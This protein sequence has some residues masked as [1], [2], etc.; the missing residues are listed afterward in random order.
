MAPGRVL[1]IRRGQALSPVRHSRHDDARQPKAA[2]DGPPKGGAL[3]LAAACILSALATE[4]AASGQ[5]VRDVVVP[6]IDGP[7]WTV[8]G[9]PDLGD[10][11][12]PQQQP[13]DFAIWQAADGSWQLWSCI[14][15]TRCGGKSRLFYRWEGPRLTQG[16][17]R[18][19][20]IAM[21]ADKRFGETPGGLQA[22]HV[23]RTGD[24][25][26]M[27]YGDWENICLATSEDGKTFTRQLSDDGRAGMFGEGAGANT[28]D[29]MAILVGDL[30]HCYYTAFPGGKGAVYC[31]TSRDLRNWS[32]SR[33][34]SYGG[35]AGSGP[36]SAECAHV[37]YHEGHYYLFRT[38][39]YGEDAQTSVYRSQDPMH[40]GVDDDSRF[41][42]TLPVAAPE[43]VVHEAREY[44]ASLRP[45]LKG[46]RVARLRW[47]EGE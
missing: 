23:V 34:V 36:T 28:R 43:V 45:D 18:P 15:H 44:I 2:R 10:L 9:D 8:A 42:G 30:W 31:R 26:H 21:Q 7:W 22:P 46:I 17:W 38:Q 25:Y 29:P 24:R 14:R 37:V 35:R 39:R 40:F 13:V 3:A 20:G 12:D 11:T 32:A 19:M 6:Q 16:D 4:P 1:R 27:L 47:A 5:R 41:V 33:I